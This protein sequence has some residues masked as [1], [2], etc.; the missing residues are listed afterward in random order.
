MIDTPAPKTVSYETP[1]SSFAAI[2]C[3]NCGYSSPGRFCTNCG[4][5]H[6]TPRDYTLTHFLRH[7]FEEFTSLDSKIFRSLKSLLFSPGK[8]TAEWAAGKERSYI[9]P[10]QLFLVLNLVYFVFQHF[11]PITTFTAPLEVQHHMQVYSAW[12]RPIIDQQVRASGLT[13]SR[14]ALV[15]NEATA[16]QAR[17]L[18]ILMVPM[19][20]A[21]LGILYFRKGRYFVEHLVFSLHFYAF[22]LVLVS[23]GILAMEI[24]MSIVAATFQF[25]LIGMDWDT[26]FTYLPG[27]IGFVYLLIALRRVYGG[28]WAISAVKSFVLTYAVLYIIFAYRFILFFTTIYTMHVRI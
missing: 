25:S 3:A 11:F 2:V 6:R 23:F 1:N 19:F 12:I 15:Y 26:W 13:Y 28:G 17:S 22:F 9:K 5:K 21:L 14:Y 24:I 27:L 8:L 20:A 10:I 18:I 16:A 7:V 4:Q